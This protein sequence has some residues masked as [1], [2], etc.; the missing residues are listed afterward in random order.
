MLSITEICMIRVIFCVCFGRKMGMAAAL[1]PKPKGSGASDLTKKLV[2]RMD[3]QVNCYLHPNQFSKILILNPLKGG[4]DFMIVVGPKVSFS[5][6]LF[7]RVF[8]VFTWN[9]QNMWT[10]YWV[11][12]SCYLYLIFDFDQKV[13]LSKNIKNRIR[14]INTIIVFKYH[15]LFKI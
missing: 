7:N 9:F 4:Y 1:I 13:F 8:S 10:F 3:L 5:L 15:Y 6:L 14:D 2:Y 11:S 12:P